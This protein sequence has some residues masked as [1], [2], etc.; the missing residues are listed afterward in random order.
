[1][2]LVFFD[3]TAAFLSMS[4]R[5]D[6]VIVTYLSNA[7]FSS[8]SSTAVHVKLV[9]SCYTYMAVMSTSL[10]MAIPTMSQ[11]STTRPRQLDM[12]ILTVG[13]T[14]FTSREGTEI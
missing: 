2:L 1:M 13:A 5:C 9:W 4:C 3:R 6:C 7:L 14:F 8:S 11:Y 12:H 10:G